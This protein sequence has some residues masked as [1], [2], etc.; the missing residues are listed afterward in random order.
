MAEITFVGAADTVTGSKHLVTTNGKRFFVDCGLFQGT[1]DI[2]ALNNLPLP[3]PA[4]SIDAVVITHGHIDH[5]GYL[6]K[7]VRSGFRGPIYC[8]PP[9]KALMRIVLEDAASLQEHLNSRGFHREKHAPPPFYDDADV[10]RTMQLAQD[11]PLHQTF[12]VCGSQATYFN[13]GHIIGSAFVKFQMEGKTVAF[14]G[15]LGRYGR[16]LLFD[17]ET[18]GAAD[19]VVCE[20]T[21]GDR[22]HPPDPLADLGAAILAGIKLGGTIVIPAFAVERTQDMLLAIGELQKEH[23]ELADIS[24]DLDSPMAA[25][26][27]QLFDDF[28]DSHRRVDG[29]SANRPFSCANLR[30]DVSTE[31]SKA[32]NDLPGPN[33]IVSSSGMLNGG[34]VL[35]HLHR[36]IGDAKSTIIF[37]GYQATG[38][39]G[40]ELIRGVETVRL[41]GDTIPVCAKISNVLGYSAHADRN[42]I[43]RWLQT[44]TSTPRFYA[45]HGEQGAATVLCEAVQQQLHWAADVA[46]RGDTVTV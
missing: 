43:L 30:V 24:V 20:S 32:L 39:L 17:P 36:H 25:K 15:D 44:C 22:I 19:V 8:T 29:A 11:V 21:Y 42:G 4:A 35:H 34:R 6:P 18:L 12:D 41:F 3:V 16:P 26:V 10:Q 7:L 5:V 31:E 9:T 23:S 37:V 1:R 27:D 2:T 13:S 33:I 40:A 45:V 28:P 14:S 38:T 46:H